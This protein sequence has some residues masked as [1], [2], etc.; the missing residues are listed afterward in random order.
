MAIS[1]FKT[2]LMKKGDGTAY[3]KVIDI[4]SF[5][6]IG[7]QREMLD[8]TTM[9]DPAHTYIDGIENNSSGIQFTC[10]YTKADYN[11]LKGLEGTEHDYSIW[12]GATVSGATVTPTGTD[13]KFN[14]KGLLSVYVN[15][16]NVNEVV[17]MT[18]TIANTTAPA[19]VA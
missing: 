6:D 10:N 5:G 1:T 19:I 8:T 9:S 7:G 17:N 11:T 18:V 12:F 2:F 4:K 14:F 15:G 16:G 3:A 13:G